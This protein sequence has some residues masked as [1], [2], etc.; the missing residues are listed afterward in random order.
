ALS[1]DIEAARNRSRPE[2][3]GEP[4]TSLIVDRRLDPDFRARILG[5]GIVFCSNRQR[6][7]SRT[8][9]RI[10]R[11]VL[12]SNT[13][14][15]QSPA[16]NLVQPFCPVLFLR[17]LDLACASLCFDHSSKAEGPIRITMERAVAVAT[18][19]GTDHDGF[20]FHVHRGVLYRQ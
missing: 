19:N 14:A 20:F 10:K 16:R 5:V 11:S 8:C 15:V 2:T 9:R 17:L 7:N 3:S 4:Q 12:K 18:L 1:I 13:K 6:G